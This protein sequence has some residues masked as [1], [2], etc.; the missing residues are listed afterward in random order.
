MR[1]EDCKLSSQIS[2]ILLLERN[3]CLSIFTEWIRVD[4]VQN[5]PKFVE[6]FEHSHLISSFFCNC[7]HKTLC[8]APLAYKY[9]DE[10]HSLFLATRNILVKKTLT[11]FIVAMPWPK[12]EVRWYGTKKVNFWF[13]NEFLIAIWLDPNYA[14]LLVGYKFNWITPYGLRCHTH[15]F[16]HSRQF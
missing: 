2:R 14:C 11:V 3:K 9:M 4:F 16:M 7:L 10:F 12:H 5:G 1:N 6:Y 8:F 13:V 15:I